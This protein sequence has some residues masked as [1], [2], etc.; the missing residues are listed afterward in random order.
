M[1]DLLTSLD[2]VN[3]SFKKCMRGYDPVE[4]DEFLDHVAG[5]LQAY[6]QKIKDQEQELVQKRE[7]LGQ[8]ES[9]RESIQEALIMAQRTAEERVQGARMQA[10]SIISE[11]RS[12]VDRMVRDAEDEMEALR[13][14]MGRLRS[15]RQQ[16]VDEFRELLQKFDALLD[17]SIEEEV[18]SSAESSPLQ[19]TPVYVENHETTEF[20]QFKVGIEDALNAIGVDPRLLLDPSKMGSV[21]YQ[22]DSG[23]EVGSGE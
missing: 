5:S 23:H 3:Q 20:P 18:P 15:S 21:T 2:V 4:V 17:E 16:Y 13:I 11:A 8:F 9:I 6:V 10:D 14:D 7:K 22:S 19:P 12:K 1:N